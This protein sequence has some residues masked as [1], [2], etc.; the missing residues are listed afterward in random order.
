MGNRMRT[1]NALFACA[2]LTSGCHH[3][4]VIDTGEKPPQVGGTISGIVR[5]VA[6]TPLSARKVTA[7]ETTSGSRLEET[8]AVN[9]G[10]T[11][12]VPTGTYRLDVEL[13]DGETLATRPDP[14]QVNVGDLDGQRDFV[15]T[16]R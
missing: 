10:Y 5:S 11:I 8:T 1:V 15:V 14:T 12:K 13:R 3:Q 6:G 16:A 2:L 4:P 7:T 9:G